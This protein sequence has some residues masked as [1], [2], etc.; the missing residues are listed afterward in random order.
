MFLADHSQTARDNNDPYPSY[1]EFW[2]QSNI[3]NP[4][5]GFQNLYQSDFI[6]A[7]G[8]VSRREMDQLTNT[9]PYHQALVSRGISKHQEEEEVKPKL[10]QAMEYARV[11]GAESIEYVDAL[12]RRM[13]IAVEGL[14]L[15][16]VNLEMRMQGVETAQGN[17][18]RIQGVVADAWGRAMNVS[19][20]VDQMEVD[21][22]QLEERMENVELVYIEVDQRV[23]QLE[24]ELANTQRDVAML[25][26]EHDAQQEQWE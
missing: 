21:I 24:W 20:T 3:D 15:S 13:V 1:Q 14:D 9:S 18:G 4:Q 19:D 8:Y 10:V 22:E 12:D 26:A 11:I 25:V 6:S 16:V 17:L 5:S 7:V 23:V 2:E